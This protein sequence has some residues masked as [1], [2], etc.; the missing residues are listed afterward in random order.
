MK[1]TQLTILILFVLNSWINTAAFGQGV[2]KSGAGGSGR[3]TKTTKPKPVGTQKSTILK[4][5]TKTGSIP[6][7]KTKPG[8]T[9]VKPAAKT[10]APP[11]PAMS[12]TKKTEPPENS[13]NTAIGLR[14]GGTSGL[15]IKQFFATG[16]AA[17]GIFGIW[18]NAISITALYERYSQVGDINGM[19]WYFGGGGH[20]T[21][22]T[23][24]LYYVYREGNRY[25]TYRYNYPGFG[26]G[27]DLVA[28]IEYKIP[29]IPFAFN[30]DIKPF[31]EM[32]RAGVLF[33]AFDPGLGIKITF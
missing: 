3:A 2:N 24:R 23:G 10:Q 18:P 26:V 9:S 21:C 15:T 1:T 7:T 20:I 4:A 27:I 11:A 13:Y 33:T 30:V 6:G 17:E 5:V 29:Q 19:N 22:G 32:N 14:A 16:T 12:V 28:G 31:I 25:Y 8:S